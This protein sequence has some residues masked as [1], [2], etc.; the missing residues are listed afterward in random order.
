VQVRKGRPD[1]A[2]A[3]ARVHVASWRAAYRRVM[4]DAVLDRLDEAA[5]AGT[6]RR[7]LAD[8]EWPVLVLDLDGRVEGFCHVAPSRDPRVDRARTAEI[9]AIY[10]DPS[11]WRRGHGRALCRRALEEAVRLG[12]SEVTLWV[13]EKNQSA[14]RFYEALGFAEDGG[15]KVE[16]ESGLREV[17]YRIGVEPAGRGARQAP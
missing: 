14:R 15:A 16:P 11:F 10:I 8:P 3:I 12:R 4:P 7:A 9:T 1:D 17:R 2:D 6:W 5:R 13:L